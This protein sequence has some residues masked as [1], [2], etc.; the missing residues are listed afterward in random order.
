MPADTVRRTPAAHRQVPGIGVMG[1]GFLMGVD[2]RE[3][4]G[5]VKSGQHVHDFAGH[6]MQAA[7][8]AAQLAIHLAQAFED[9]LSS[10]WR[11]AS[12]CA[13]RLGSTM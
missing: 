4:L 5:G 10:C 6:H 13:Q 2:S 3:G 7:A 12:G 1:A 8:Q 11:A 9:E